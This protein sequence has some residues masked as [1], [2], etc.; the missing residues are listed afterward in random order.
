MER[1]EIGGSKSVAIE[2]YKD[3]C[4]ILNT[5]VGC[6][7]TDPRKLSIKDFTY[8]LP[9]E[10]IAKYPL[11]E[12]DASRL[13]IYKEGVIEESIYKNIAEHIPGGS[14]IIFND[15]KVLEARLIFQKPSGGFVEI[16]C[17]EQHEQ[18][19][20][21]TTALLQQEKVLWHC[22]IGGASKWKHGHILEKKIQSSNGEI[23]IS[24]QYIEKRSDSFVI[25]LS[26]QP[27][28]LS[29]AEILHD[30]GAIPLPPYIKRAA[31]LSDKERYQTVYAHSHGSVAAPTAGLHFTPFIFDEL[32]TKNIQTGFVTLHV[33]AGTFKPV[34]TDAM[35]EH[36]MHAE[37]MDVSKETIEQLLKNIEGTIIA[38]GTTSLRTIESLYWLGVKIS[39]GSWQSS[40]DS[41]QSL[42]ELSQ[43]EVYD[44]PKQD[45]PVKEALQSLLHWMD[46]NK[47]ERLN[48]KTQIIVVPG[49]Q[50]KIAKALITN[51]HQ[52]QSTLL[53]LVAALIGK[54]WKKVYEYAL[55]NEYRF[56]T[57]GDGSLLWIHEG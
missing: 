52:P 42:F 24:A 49:Y 2:Y 21:I 3:I 15:T 36:E 55:E 54:D 1:I 23:T 19:T 7:M 57:Y 46:Q 5:T 47:L 22:L 8:P 28:S 43:W 48:T 41:P 6:V 11:A 13:L 38:A 10:K 16:F 33:G 37:Y 45:M 40:V 14:L 25:E 53:L 32:K 9:E 39:V 31:E 35:E 27:A 30:A 29:F 34:K 26:W 50:L 17:L 12:R 20:D 4:S 51:F 56:L 18:Y 44:T